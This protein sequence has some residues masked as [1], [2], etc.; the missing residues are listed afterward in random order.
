VAR[1]S[2]GSA[3]LPWLLTLED[4]DVEEWFDAF[5]WLLRKEYPD[6]S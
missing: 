6:Q 5:E 1:Y 4:H 3:P 2:N